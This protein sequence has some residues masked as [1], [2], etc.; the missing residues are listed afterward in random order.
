MRVL[1]IGEFS[2]LH[3]Y[4]KEGLLELGQMDVT[5]VSNSDGWKEIGGADIKLPIIKN[6]SPMEFMR[7]YRDVLKKYRLFC[8]FDV[9]QYINPN[10]FPMAF[11][12]K[13][14]KYIRKNNNCVSLAAAAD[15]AAR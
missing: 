7:A 2:S 12:S 15:R 9:V 5:L 14:H 4:L 10:V 13:F 3:K 11:A 1:L 6:S 8:D